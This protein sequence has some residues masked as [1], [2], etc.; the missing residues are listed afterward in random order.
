MRLKRAARGWSQ[1]ALQAAL[2]V[3]GLG[4]LQV[5]AERTNRRIDLTPGR[6]LSLSPVTL[7]VLAEVTEPLRLTVFHRR[8][9][10]ARYGDLLARLADANPHVTIELLDLDRHPDR[11]RSLGVTEYGQAAVEYRGNR[12]VTRAFPEEDLAG[13]ILRAV[14]GRPRRLVYTTG[15][16]ERSP[17]GGPESFGRLTAAL[18]AESY[19]PEAVSLLDAPLPADADVVV[20]AGPQHDFVP[21]EL[22]ALAAFLEGGG[23]VLMLLDPA[24]LPQLG[25]FLDSMG[26]RLGDDFLVDR[27]RR[28]LGTDGLAAVV[29]LFKTGNPI[30]DPEGHPIDTGVVLP[31]ARSVD[32]AGPVPGVD[33]ESIARTAAS[34][35]AMADPD[36]ARRGEEPDRAHHDVPGSASVVVMAEVGPG[37]GPAHRRGRLVVVGDADFASDAYLDLLGNRDLAINAVAWV[38]AEE[39]LVGPHEERTPEVLRPLSPLVLSERQARTILLAAAIGEPGLVLALGLGIAAV[40]RRRG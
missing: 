39:A 36:R 34:G 3:V 40:R 31:S 17:G 4:L 33:A 19:A 2:L 35:W 29:E 24:P 15:H 23:G 32:V 11:A 8:G 28:I 9:Q 25:R 21:P 14:R 27:E 37:G 30:T 1:L 38:A 20:I 5:V 6:A 13:G 7:R 18:A 22:A 10:R 16:G 12:V 26:L